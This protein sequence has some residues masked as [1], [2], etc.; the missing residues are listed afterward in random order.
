M[1]TLVLEITWD[2]Y[3]AKV[4]SMFTVGIIAL[5]MLICTIVV[6]VDGLIDIVTHVKKAVESPRPKDLEMMNEDRDQ[7]LV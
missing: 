5:I 2:T 6:C 7:I 3:E 4:F 1:E